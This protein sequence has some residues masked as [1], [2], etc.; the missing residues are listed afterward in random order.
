MADYV[1]VGLAQTLL[2][3]TVGLFFILMGPAS[4]R[5]T[6]IMMRAGSP[7]IHWPAHKYGLRLIWSLIPITIAPDRH[8]GDVCQDGRP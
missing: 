5:P 6:S 7:P 2:W 3:K 4:S 8:S 1:E